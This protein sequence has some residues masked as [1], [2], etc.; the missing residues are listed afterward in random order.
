MQQ[1]NGNF[2]ATYRIVK[3]MEIDIIKQKHLI[4]FG[5]GQWLFYKSIKVTALLGCLVIVLLE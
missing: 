2:T 1:F 3:E 4:V 5:V